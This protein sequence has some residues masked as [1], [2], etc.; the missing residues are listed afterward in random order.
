VIQQLS[1]NLKVIQIALFLGMIGI[2]T[3]PAFAQQF[4][5]PNYVIEGGEV[6]DF[7]IDSET[8]SLIISLNAKSRGEII[9]TLPRNL[10]D[11]KSGNEDIDFTVLIDGLGYQF[12]V[13]TVTPTDRTITIPLLKFNAE[14]IIIG[15]QVFSQVT[16]APT[17]QP[18]QQIEKKIEEELRSE[19]TGGKAKLLIFSDT[20]WSGAVVTWEKICVPIIIISKLCF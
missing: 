20:K 12:F 4:T 6:L 3:S 17:I 10:I 18:Q 5:D 2:F 8:K 9:I 19:I 7:K 13:E 14:I 11:A 1:V 15:T 16:P